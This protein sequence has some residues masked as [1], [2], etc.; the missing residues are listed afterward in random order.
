MIAWPLDVPALPIATPWDCPVA[1]LIRHAERPQIQAHD[2]GTAL[3]LTESG[4][5][6][7][8][9]LGAAIAGNLRRIF[10]SPVRRCQETALAIRDGACAAHRP[11]D[12]HH[13]G[14]PG[15]FIADSALAWTTWQGLGHAAVMDHL[16][17]ST[18][19]LPGMVAPQEGVRRLLAHIANNLLGATP[20]FHLF[21]THDAVLFPTIARTLPS[22]AS[23]DW[24]PAFLEA[25]S[26][27][28]DATTL[29]FNY[30]HES[31]P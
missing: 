4:R 15:V 25:A 1:L 9:A 11:I 21:I 2:P 13:L 5:L 3:P 27:W 12:D 10:T 29:R 22:A 19:P 23:R 26:V 7:A 6:H 30:R 20:G 17:W 18:A 16:A 14:D 28:R 24:W 31:A 8:Q